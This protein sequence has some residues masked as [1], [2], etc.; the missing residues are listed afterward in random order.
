MR[1]TCGKPGYVTCCR[2]RSSGKTSCSI[3]RSAARCVAPHGGTVCV[4]SV[5]SCCDACGAG[6]CNTTSTTSTTTST[7][8]T[9]TMDPFAPCG[10]V[11]GGSCGGMCPSFFD[12]CDSDPDTGE[13]VCVLGP[14]QA[15]GGIGSCGGSCSNPAASCSFYPGGCAC[16]IPCDPSE[17]V[18][19]CSFPQGCAFNEFTSSCVCGP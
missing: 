5:P 14:C 4:G 8:S 16:I 19:A 11:G 18:P 12:V 3:K 7:S 6:G 1:S 2:T 9:T 15:I 17:C 13:C 10:P